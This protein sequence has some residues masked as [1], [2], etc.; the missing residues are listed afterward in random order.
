M[1][2]FNFY[3]KTDSGPIRKIN[4]DGALGFIVNDTLFLIVVDGFG[5]EDDSV[6]TPNG[7]LIATE[8]Q[9]FIEKH[10]TFQSV[11]FLKYILEESIYLANRITRSYQAANQ[12]VYKNYGASITICGVLKDYNMVLTHAGITRLYMIRNGQPFLGTIDHNEANELLKANKI[13]DMEYVNHEKRNI[14]TNGLGY[15]DN[16]APFTTIAKVAK[17]DFI[18]LMSDGVYRT[19]GD[20]KMVNLVLEAGE[21]ET[22]CNWLIDAAYEMKSLDNVSAIIS[23][24]L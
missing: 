13:T 6:G 12:E 10:Y 4:E 22:A 8:V 19:L 14:M 11:E 23:Y 15:S 20:E 5:I 16:I 18:L 9:S 21:L 24:I 7:Q 1:L 17:G 2:E 3:S